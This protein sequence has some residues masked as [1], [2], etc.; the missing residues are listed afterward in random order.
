MCFSNTT[1]LAFI[2]SMMP[3]KNPANVGLMLGTLKNN[4]VSDSSNAADG[5]VMQIDKTIKG[6]NTADL[7]PEKRLRGRIRKFENFLL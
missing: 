2:E 7:F 6:I 3:V 1:I 5:T 4:S